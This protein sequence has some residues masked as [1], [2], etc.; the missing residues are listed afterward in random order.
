MLA[1]N[2]VGVEGTMTG[3]CRYGASSEREVVV[4][5][6][7]SVGTNDVERSRRFYD[8]VLPIVGILPMA[9]DEG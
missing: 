2:A 8:A 3:I 9:E 7:V 4:I 6:H 1:E 5:H